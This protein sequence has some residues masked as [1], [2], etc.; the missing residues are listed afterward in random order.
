M[1][2][3][4]IFNKKHIPHAEKE[5][6]TDITE[7][8]EFETQTD[9]LAESM[10]GANPTE[11]GSQKSVIDEASDYI[12]KY[13]DL[14]YS[15]SQTN[16]SLSM[17][18]AKPKKSSLTVNDFNSNLSFQ[19]KM[20]VKN[21]KFVPEKEN[22]RIMSNEDDKSVSYVAKNLRNEKDVL[23]QEVVNLTREITKL[24]VN[25]KQLLLI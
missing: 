9:E 15:Q 16:V 12:H 11:R 14:M 20:A 25:H 18:G 10:R 3:D 22:S 5:A 4:T 13:S 2:G 19:D 24:K 7:T 6:Q 23:A 8:K 17:S 1:K 21:L